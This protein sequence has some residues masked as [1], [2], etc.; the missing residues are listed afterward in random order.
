[1]LDLDKP[2]RPHNT[3]KDLPG[4]AALLLTGTGFIEAQEARGAQEAV[5]SQTLPTPNARVREQYEALGFVFGEPF[6]DDPLFCFVTM[7]KGWEKR[8]TDHSMHNDIVDAA[9]NVR[10]SFFYKASFY[11]RS[12]DLHAPNIRYRV[13]EHYDDG[14]RTEDRYDQHKIVHYKVIDTANDNIILYDVKRIVEAVPPSKGGDHRAFW[15]AHEELTKQI[16]DE[17]KTWLS[18][19]F[20]DWTSPAAYWPT[21]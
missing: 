8:R 3:S 13:R 12:A 14:P 21:V 2:V 20:P 19:N 16:F 18:E 4:A 7:P 9:G 17:C 11:D 1:M 5:E 10:G 6:A 15:N